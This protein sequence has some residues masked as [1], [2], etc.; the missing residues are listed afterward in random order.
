[1]NFTFKG[2]RTEPRELDESNA[3]VCESK[4]EVDFGAQSAECDK[5]NDV[6]EK[7]NEIEKPIIENGISEECE[8]NVINAENPPEEKY[9]TRVDAAPVAA[10]LAEA[11]KSPEPA[12][13][14]TQTVLSDKEVKND[15]DVDQVS[16]DEIANGKVDEPMEVVDLDDSRNDDVVDIS[17]DE[18]ENATVAAVDRVAGN[19]LVEP[20][21]G[22]EKEAE[23]VEDSAPVLIDDDDEENEATDKSS[24]TTEPAIVVLSSDEKDA[25]SSDSIPDSPAASV[26][27]EKIDSIVDETEA[28][29]DETLADPNNGG[30]ENI[31]EADKLSSDN[32]EPDNNLLEEMSKKDSSDGYSSPREDNLEENIYA[33]DDIEIDL[34]STLNIN[35]LLEAGDGDVEMPE[36]AEEIAEETTEATADAAAK[37]TDEAM[38]EAAAEAPAICIDTVESVSVVSASA[39]GEPKEMEIRI[40]EVNSSVAVSVDEKAPE[41]ADVIAVDEEADGVTAPEKENEEKAFEVKES[42]VE[43]SPMDVAEVVSGEKV[44]EMEKPQTSDDVSAKPAAQAD[45]RDDEDDDDIMLIE[46]DEIDSSVVS[47]KRSSPPEAEVPAKKFKPSLFDALKAETVEIPEE[48]PLPLDVEKASADTP[49]ESPP[50]EGVA[51]VEVESEK[52]EVETAVPADEKPVPEA[53]TPEPSP[54]PKPLALVPEPSP[55]P[56]RSLQLEFLSKFKKSFDMMSRSDLEQLVLQKITEAIVHRSECSELRKKASE[57]EELISKFRVKFLEV[58]KQYQDL[59][60]VHQRLMKDME[61]SNKTHIAPLK[62]TRAVGLQVSLGRN[63]VASLAPSIVCTQTKPSE[64]AQKQKELLKARLLAPKAPE[65][66]KPAAAAVGQAKQ[67]TPNDPRTYVIRQRVTGR[68]MQQAQQMHSQL[69]QQLNR[70]LLLNPGAPNIRP[71][72]IRV[73]MRPVRSTTQLPPRGAL[74]QLRPKATV[75]QVAQML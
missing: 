25:P 5:S 47:L 10:E 59:D 74:P 6:I 62:I 22:K 39:E 63:S 16:T 49:A 54:S 56:K 21:S 40:A 31:S 60:S 51:E 18:E 13:S 37:L 72:N 50:T 46:P 71:Q 24:A 34:D 36:P 1:M 2:E 4:G 3:V 75:Q 64:A 69:A 28:S 58:E 9:E 20:K 43:A 7:S 38:D 67:A 26:S 55:A 57:Q 12:E 41:P 14:V 19:A 52:A 66:P 70:P 33:S 32:N 68:L 35:G 23:K 73:Q 17:S 15:K 27:D 53:E 11:E 30:K 44:P 61:D 48:K 29:V 45:T 8:P 42:A 65:P